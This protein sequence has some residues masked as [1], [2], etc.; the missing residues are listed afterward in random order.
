MGRLFPAVFTEQ[1]VEDVYF[2]ECSV[3]GPNPVLY[4]TT[5]KLGDKL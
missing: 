4:Q 1:Q 3:W 5:S 2:V